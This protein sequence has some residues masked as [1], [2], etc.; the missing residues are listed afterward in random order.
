MTTESRSLCSYV[1]SRPCRILKSRTCLS[2]SGITP[3]ICSLNVLFGRL[4]SDSVSDWLAFSFSSLLGWPLVAR[5]LARP[6]YDL[7]IFGDG[8]LNKAANNGRCN[9]Y[10]LKLGDW[11]KRLAIKPAVCDGDDFQR[12]MPV[13]VLIIASCASRADSV[14]IDVETIAPTP[15]TILINVNKLRS[16]RL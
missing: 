1:S 11:F 3:R 9:L 13:T 2:S 16:G 14:E 6:I 10:P 8:N 5:Q 12:C 7:T 4:S 15:I